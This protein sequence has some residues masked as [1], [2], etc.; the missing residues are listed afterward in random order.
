MAERAQKLFKAEYAKYT[1]EA[2]KS[3]S[4]TSSLPATSTS[5]ASASRSI[6][7]EAVSAPTATLSGMKS[8]VALYT[9]PGA[10][11]WFDKSDES[12]L[13]FWKVCPILYS[14]QP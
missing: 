1:S 6:F 10:F 4:K 13:L 9:E 7:A 14:W 2:A 5:T 3:A 8:E 12:A 11:A